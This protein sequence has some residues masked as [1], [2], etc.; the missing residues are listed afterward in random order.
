[1]KKIDKQ[2]V[3][4]APPCSAQQVYLLGTFNHDGTLLLQ[5]QA[6][7]SYIPGPPEGKIVNVVYSEQMKENIL[8]ENVVS[9]N[10]CNID[11]LPL[12]ELAWRGYIPEIN[13]ENTVGYI[14]GNKLNVPIID[15]SPFVE[16]LKVI[17]TVPIGDTLIVISETVCVHADKT[18]VH[19]YSDSDDLYEWYLKHNASDFNSLMYSVKY[20]TLRE[21]VANL[22][23]DN[24]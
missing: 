21:S 14:N 18:L 13:A 22:E 24:W 12:V 5:T 19:P 16:E 23:K 2:I 6:F 7:V 17:Q 3:E 1:M 15:S 9:L 20:Y 8:R 10:L 11:M 4:I